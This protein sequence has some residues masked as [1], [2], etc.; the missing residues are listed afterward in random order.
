MSCTVLAGTLSNPAVD[1]YNV[2][3]GTETFAGHYKFTTNTLLVE[4]AEAITNLGSDTIKFYL[5]SDTSLQSG[6]T[7]PGGVTNLITL[8]RN[9]PSYKQV[10]DMPFR[11]LIMWAY[12]F[13]TG[14]SWWVNG[15]NTTQG[16]KDYREMYDLTCY[17][18]TNYNNS[19]KTFYLGH[20]EGDGYLDV[21]NWSPIPRPSPSRG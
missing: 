18:L 14:D 3:V 9:E 16:A 2:R 19:G 13:A 12:P 20:W 7:L 4:T 15:Y 5:G 10:L 8:A 17:L 6:V 1:A 11:H 21:N